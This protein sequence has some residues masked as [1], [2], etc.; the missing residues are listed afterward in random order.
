MLANRI[1]EQEG[2]KAEYVVFED[3]NLLVVDT[4]E[5]TDYIVL[6]E[7]DCCTMGIT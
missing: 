5:A 3:T 2:I 4:N 6:V 7:R 1:S